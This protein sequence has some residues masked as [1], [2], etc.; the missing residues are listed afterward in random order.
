MGSTQ[1][2][3]LW[4]KG[5]WRLKGKKQF[6]CFLPLG[7]ANLGRLQSEDGRH[8]LPSGMKILREEVANKEESEKR[9]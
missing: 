9:R 2:P 5:E 8:H 3:I 6:G 7:A 4:E 1:S